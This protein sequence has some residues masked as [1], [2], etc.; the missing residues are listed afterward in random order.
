MRH[1]KASKR[2]GRTTAHRKAMMRNLVTSL[3]EHG[4]IRTTLAKAKAMRSDFDHMIGL[5]KRGDLHARRQALAFVKS[6]TVIDKLFS[7]YGP[8]FKDRDGGYTRILKLGRRLGDNAEIALIQMI[9]EEEK[10]Q[11]AAKAKK[12][13]IEEVKKD[14][15]EKKPKKQKA[16]EKTAPE[17][18]KAKETLAEEAAPEKATTEKE[19]EE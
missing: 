15:T 17:T 4:Q 3:L 16:S 7:E 1:L 19:G 9:Q 6:K 8:L 12:A 2:L 10:A 14:L 5:A 18:A 13:K 11:P